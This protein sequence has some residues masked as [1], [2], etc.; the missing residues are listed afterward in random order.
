MQIGMDRE[1]PT[2]T[3]W[4]RSNKESEGQQIPKIKSLWES[5]SQVTVVV[6]EPGC[7][8]YEKLS[9]WVYGT[10]TLTPTQ[11]CELH[12]DFNHRKLVVVESENVPQSEG[13]RSKISLW[14]SSAVLSHSHSALRQGTENRISL[15]QGRS[16]KTE[17]FFPK[18]SHKVKNITLIFLTFPC[19]C[20]P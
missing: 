11:T 15:P 13:L 5:K 16:Y 9:V 6:P 10:S 1:V 18:G 4:R 14:L 20:W 2:R 8:Y 19:H 12:A 7:G 17:P 3:Q